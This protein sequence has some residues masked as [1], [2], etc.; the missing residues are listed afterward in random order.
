MNSID[1]A[2]SLFDRFSQEYI[3]SAHTTVEI[4]KLPTFEINECNEKVYSQYEPVNQILNTLSNSRYTLNK[5]GKDSGNLVPSFLEYWKFEDEQY[6]VLHMLEPEL[7]KNQST[8]FQIYFNLKTL[9]YEIEVELRD[10]IVKYMTQLDANKS[11]Q[12]YDALNLMVSTLSSLLSDLSYILRSNIITNIHSFSSRILTDFET[13][14]SSSEFIN[15]IS[16]FCN[17]APT[18]LTPLALKLSSFNCLLPT[19][20]LHLELILVKQ[21]LERITNKIEK[22]HMRYNLI[23]TITQLP[24][25]VILFPFITVCWIIFSIKGFCNKSF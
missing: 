13:L 3:T 24:Q 18:Q 11:R 6:Q 2:S 23:Q 1:S 12:V 25:I 8:M 14:E 9:K 19:T 7:L 17:E 4:G 10:N 15:G 5:L 16:Y 22:E 20:S 21:C